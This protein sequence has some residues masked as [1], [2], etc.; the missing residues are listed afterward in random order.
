[1]NGSGTTRGLSANG[2]SNRT[3]TV[4]FSDATRACPI[5]SSPE[6]RSGRGVGH[7]GLARMQVRA[8][9]AVLPRRKPIGPDDATGF[10]WGAMLGRELDG[11]RAHVE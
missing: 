2:R 7:A 1:M 4:S 3:A 11:R 5:Q 9:R 8:G 6:T 10:V